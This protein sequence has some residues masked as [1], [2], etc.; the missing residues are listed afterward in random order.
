M[1]KTLGSI[2]RE[3]LL[4]D[5]KGRGFNL[6]QRSGGRGGYS[7]GEYAPEE[8]EEGDEG[9][10]SDSPAAPVGRAQDFSFRGRDTDDLKDFIAVLAPEFRKEF[11]VEMQVGSTYRNPYEQAKAMAWTLDVPSP[12]NFNDLYRGVLGANLAHVRQLVVDKKWEEAG[13]IIAATPLATRS[14]GGGRAFDLGF[15][16]NPV[17]NKGKHKQYKDLV[18][19]VAAEHGFKAAANGEKDNH[20]HVDVLGRTRPVKSAVAANAEPKPA[21]QQQAKA[22]EDAA[23]A[24]AQAQAESVREATK[25]A[26]ADTADMWERI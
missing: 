21:E 22:G 18:A 11:G 9:Q 20:F 14:H 1:R 26:P 17:L 13:N 5:I 6:W 7:R 19:R 24:A 15:G 3:V 8:G 23:P 2:V 12:N 4:E 16:K 10:D 25:S